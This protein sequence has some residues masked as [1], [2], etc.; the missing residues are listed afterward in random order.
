MSR[1]CSNCAGK[2]ADSVAAARVGSADCALPIGPGSYV[3]ASFVA[4]L[5]LARWLAPSLSGAFA[6]KFAG[7]LLVT[8][9]HNVIFLEPMTV[10]GASRYREEVS[11]YFAAN[12]RAH[13]VVMGALS[14]A[15]SIRGGIWLAWDPR[16]PLG[17]VIVAVGIGLLFLFLFWIARRMCC[18]VQDSKL[19]AGASGLYLVLL[20]GGMFALKAQGWV[21]PANTF[22]VMAGASLCA[23]LAVFL[24]L[25]IP[26]HILGDAG[27]SVRG[28]IS[29]LDRCRSATGNAVALLVDDASDCGYH[30]TVS[31][32]P[33]SRAGKG[34]HKTASR[35]GGHFIATITELSIARDFT[36]HITI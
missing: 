26:L 34:R 5:L 24:C 14:A 36:C 11:K 16:S 10:Y 25:S 1:A 4:N 15:V 30:A 20:F 27:Y 21:S 8:G 18:V 6:L 2:V 7:F 33:I 31:T 23:A 32:K 28:G 19:A 29:W 22:L 3:K 13:M 12:L 35:K 9:F 17:P